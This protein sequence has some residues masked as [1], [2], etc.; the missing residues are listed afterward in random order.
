MS[1]YLVYIKGDGEIKTDTEVW[2]ETP[3]TDYF[4]CK[5]TSNDEIEKVIKPIGNNINDEDKQT[6]QTLVGKTVTEVNEIIMKFD[7]EK[8]EG[9]FKG[10]IL[11]PNN[12]KRTF[13]YD[14]T[15]LT[16][17]KEDD[18]DDDETIVQPEQ[19]APVEELKSLNT[20][21]QELTKEDG[22]TMNRSDSVTSATSDL[23]LSPASGTGID[24]PDTQA[25]TA[26]GSRNL[27]LES[28]NSRDIGNEDLRNEHLRMM[29]QGGAKSIN[30]S[31][32]NGGK[33]KTKSKRSSKKKRNTKKKRKTQNKKK[34]SRK[35]SKK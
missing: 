22:Q 13:T 7:A 15:E 23:T 25:L 35:R 28:V 17:V 1:K 5:Y 2:K 10:D 3:R 31:P 4:A 16:I 9:V 24:T 26:L 11:F 21:L 12:D 27:E 6:L 32:V 14:G 19:D 20:I 18:V 33:R 29:K 30:S 34:S 8:Q